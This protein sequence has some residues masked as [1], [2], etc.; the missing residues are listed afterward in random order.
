MLSFINKIATA[1]WNP[2]SRV[3]MVQTIEAKEESTRS[4]MDWIELIFIALIVPMGI[5]FLL[6]HFLGV[7]KWI[8]RKFRKAPRR[9]RSSGVVAR[10]RSM[11][12]RR[13]VSTSARSKQLAALARGR[14]TRKRNARAKRKK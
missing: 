11:F 3:P 7:T 13:R 8:K 12:G 1:S 6:A 14:A 2:F 10:A 4:V 9:R 5:I